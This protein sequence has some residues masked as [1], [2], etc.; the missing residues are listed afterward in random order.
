MESI[1]TEADGRCDQPHQRLTLHWRH[2]IG[3]YILTERTSPTPRE[4]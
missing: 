4:Y 3:V 2:R 1:V